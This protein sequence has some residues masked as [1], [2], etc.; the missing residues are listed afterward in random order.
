MHSEASQIAE[1]RWLGSARATRVACAQTSD[2]GC[3]RAAAG[4]SR[5][6]TM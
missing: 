4:R 5:D 2:F 6:G 1:S 3:L